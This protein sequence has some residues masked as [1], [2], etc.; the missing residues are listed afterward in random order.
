MPHKRHRQVYL[1][2]FE[3][4]LV[5]ID[6]GQLGVRLSQKFKKG[7]KRKKKVHT[8]ESG[9]YLRGTVTSAESETHAMALTKVSL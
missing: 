3:T 4:T 1:C 8:L 5:Y 9:M 2:R 7:G 6:P